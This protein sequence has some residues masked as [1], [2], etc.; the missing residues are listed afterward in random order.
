MGIDMDTNRELLLI[1]G[2][3]GSGKTTMA[4]ENKA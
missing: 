4:K 3:S 2:L 1:R